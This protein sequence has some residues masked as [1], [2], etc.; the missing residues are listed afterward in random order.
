M[1][2]SNKYF[3]SAKH[4]TSYLLLLP[5]WSFAQFDGGEGTENNPYQVATAAQLN[6]VRNYP[7]AH[8]IQTA[9][10][11]LGGDNPDSE[12]YND[13][14]GWEPIRDGDNPFHGY[15]NGG[16]YVINGLYI[17]RPTDDL[18]LFGA[19]GDT[20]KIWNVGIYSAEVSSTSDDAFVVAILIAR[21]RGEVSGSYVTGNVDSERITGGLVGT[22]DGTIEDCYA[23]VDIHATRSGGGIAG[24]NR[25]DIVRC[26]VDGEIVQ[27]EIGNRV[28]GIA[29]GNAGGYIAHSFSMA[30]VSGVRRVGGFAGY[31]SG[32]I[33]NSFATGEVT[34]NGSVNITGAPEDFGGFTGSQNQAGSITT[35]FATGDVTAMTN[36]ENIGGLTGGNVGGQIYDSYAS[37]NVTGINNVGGLVGGGGTNTNQYFSRNYAIGEVSDYNN[38]GNLLGTNY[39]G[40]TNDNY[41]NEDIPPHRGVGDEGGPLADNSGVIGRNTEQMTHP[42]D[43]ENTYV[44]WDFDNIWTS[45]ENINDGYPFHRSEMQQVE[46]TVITPTRVLTFENWD[47][48]STWV[49]DPDENNGLPYHRLYKVPEPGVAI[50][51]T[52]ISL[53]PDETGS[54]AIQM[55]SIPEYDVYVEVSSTCAILEDSEEVLTLSFSGENALE[56]QEVHF[57]LPE[58]MNDTCAIQHAIYSEDI[59]YDTLDIPAVSSIIIE[60]TVEVS[61]TEIEI[62]PGS[63][64]T[65]NVRLLTI[66]EYDVYVELYTECEILFNDEL[67]SYHT[68]TFQADETAL[69]AQEVSVR[70]RPLPNKSGEEECLIM[71]SVNSEDA[72][73]NGYEMDDLQFRINWDEL[74]ATPPIT[75][76]NAISPNGDGNNEFL[77]IE[78]IEY[79][80]DNRVAIFNRWGD[81]VERIE[82]YD[83]QTNYWRPSGDV[84]DGQYHVVVTLGDATENETSYLVV[85]R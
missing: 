15:F 37:G 39:F 26:Y 65:Y 82:E 3:L 23:I 70:P 85:K 83:N 30:D 36:A 10:I 60:P 35:C 14:Q 66:P 77:Y 69:E 75:I 50:D 74:E 84:E 46:N 41:W 33:V 11:D 27:G 7:E 40:E 47:F 25:Q 19:T 4:L 8:F 18:G 68:L 22:N 54:Y 81:L 2:H 71:Y 13:G 20:A 51:P 62:I 48:D 38:A 42:I 16:A 45:A 73:Y 5:L 58:T 12:F 28:G 59:G 53:L 56:P 9:D 72:N 29:G 55:E 57:M 17:N 32:E 63:P 31:N 76:Y 49:V 43:L 61:E 52:F 78:N 21:N 80:E 79:Y 24:T 44:E 64:G 67:S 34:L 6:E 1:L